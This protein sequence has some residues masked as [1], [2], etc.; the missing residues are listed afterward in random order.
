MKE[1]PRF[2]SWGWKGGRTRKVAVTL[3]RMR[4]QSE[5]FER[6]AWTIS[7]EGYLEDRRSAEE[8]LWHWRRRRG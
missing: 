1:I 6:S 7:A 8:E 2:V 3:V 4:V 5:G